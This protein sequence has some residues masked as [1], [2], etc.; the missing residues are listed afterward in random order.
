MLKTVLAG[1]VALIICP[2]PALRYAQATPPADSSALAAVR[3]K[4]SRR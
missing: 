1:I 2:A 3:A 4:T